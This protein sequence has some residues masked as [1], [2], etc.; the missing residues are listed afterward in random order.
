MVMLDRYLSKYCILII[1]CYKTRCYLF[2]NMI[3][4]VLN[5]NLVSFEQDNFHVM[6]D[7]MFSKS[8]VFFSKYDDY[9]SGQ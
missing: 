4:V 8:K 3:L 1:V 9:G 6:T 2:S 5:Y 7:N